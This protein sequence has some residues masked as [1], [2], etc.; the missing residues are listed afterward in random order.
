MRPINPKSVLSGAALLALACG[1]PAAFAENG[2]GQ[3]NLVSDIQGMADHTDA[4]LVNAWGLTR[5]RPVPGG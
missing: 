3:H 5:S 2:Y 1:M 4:T